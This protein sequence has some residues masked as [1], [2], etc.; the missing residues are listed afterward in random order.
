MFSSFNA[1]S[2][3]RFFLFLFLFFFCYFGITR[4]RL[5]YR[6]YYYGIVLWLFQLSHFKP[7]ELTTLEIQTSWKL[8]IENISNNRSQK[9]KMEYKRCWHFLEF[10][11]TWWWKKERTQTKRRKIVTEYQSYFLISLLCHNHYIDIK[12][13]I[14]MSFQNKTVSLKS[15][16]IR[17]NGNA[18]TEQTNSCCGVGGNSNN[19]DNTSIYVCAYNVQNSASNALL[20]NR[21]NALVSHVAIDISC[22]VTFALPLSSLA[23]YLI[24]RNQNHFASACLCLYPTHAIHNCRR[25]NHFIQRRY[26]SV[27]LLLVCFNNLRIVLFCFVSF[28]L[29]VIVRLTWLLDL[30]HFSYFLLSGTLSVYI[31]DFDGFL[32]PIWCSSCGFVLFCLF[33]LLWFCFRFRLTFLVHKMHNCSQ[34]IGCNEPLLL[35]LICL[36]KKW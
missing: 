17:K 21:S 28:H 22:S 23:T 5:N 11:A 27:A 16:K 35:L 8:Y 34:W 18:F 29:N 26:H 36:K 24:I 12:H 32:S 3:T 7:C 15:T 13:S 31:C 1:N 25:L 20:Q 14:K 10:R 2:C 4:N 9:T 30:F 19:V 6:S 33:L